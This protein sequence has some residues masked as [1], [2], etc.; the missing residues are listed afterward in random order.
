MG[1][2]LGCT[3]GCPAAGLAGRP[4]VSGAELWLLVA[5][6]RRAAPDS[7]ARPLSSWGSARALLAPSAR[8]RL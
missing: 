4:E 5:D 3:C 8:L 7:P 2:P 6:R 1:R